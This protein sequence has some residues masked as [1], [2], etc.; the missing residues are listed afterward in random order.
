MINALSKCLVLGQGRFI[1]PGHT[2]DRGSDLNR[3]SWRWC[4]SSLAITLAGE[5]SYCSQATSSGCCTCRGQLLLTG[6]AHFR[7]CV[8]NRILLL[9][10]ASDFFNLFLQLRGAFSNKQWKFITFLL[11]SEKSL[12][13]HIEKW[14]IFTHS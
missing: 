2:Y 6:D 10:L 3:W 7:R 11:K 14:Q 4:N 8:I 5:F 9:T 13:F 12:L 1:F